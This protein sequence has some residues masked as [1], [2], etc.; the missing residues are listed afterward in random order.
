MAEAEKQLE[1]TASSNGELA[2]MSGS[3]QAAILLMALG[4]EEAAMIL[5]H[6]KPNEVQ[7]LGEAMKSINGV[8]QKQISYT[9]DQ[10]MHRV[11]DESSL[12]IES[13][14]YFKSALTRALGKEKAA[15]VLSSMELEEEEEKLSAVQWMDPRLIAKII[16]KEHPQIIATVLSQLGAEQAGAVLDLLPA[17]IH[18]DLIMRIVKLD[19][20]HPTA[21]AD[22][23]EIIHEL[24]E[25]NS[26]IALEGLG[27][28][29][30]AAEL[31]NGVS[32]ESEVR[33]LEEIEEIDND[34][35][36]DLREGMFIFE[37]LLSVDDRGI[38]TLLRDLSNDEL[39][40][41]LKGASDQMQKKIF[42]N[43]SSRAA[44]LLRDDLE[45][46]GG[47]K[48]SEVETAQRAILTVAQR[49]AEEGK[50]SLGGKGDEYV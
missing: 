49:L 15:G 45:A 40:L 13:A 8:S 33:I 41:A 27:G 7:L 29:R 16:M 19:K 31:L 39:I 4:E 47:V 32:K 35:M 43:M 48:L 5:R 25:D 1:E 17:E 14:S 34:M 21:L 50:I 6:L 36:V 30:V 23:N 10:F 46:K 26:T 44:E 24:F 20:L 22:L 9:L 2:P 11:K 3:F 42:K 28:V 12:G 38:Q 37:N 18:S